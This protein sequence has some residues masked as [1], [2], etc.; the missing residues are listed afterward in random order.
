M[1]ES[2]WGYNQELDAYREE[3]V[4]DH[5]LCGRV[6][7]EHKERYVVITTKQ[8]YQCE[9]LGNLRHTAT[10]RPD[11][12]AVGDW[13]YFQ[14][15]DEDRGIIHGLFPRKTLL[16][17]QAVGK[18][19]E[20]QLI[21]TNID[22]AFIL[23]ALDRDFS[24]NRIQRYLALLAG[25]EIEAKVLLT[26]GDLMSQ[27]QVDHAI[28][29]A[30]RR[31]PDIEVISVS[32]KD[33]TG[34][35][36]IHEI[37]QA[38]K[39]YCLLGSSGVGKSTLLNNLL[40]HEEMKTGNTS[41]SSNRGKHVTTHRHLVMLDSGAMI[42]DNPGMREVGMVE[43]DGELESVFG[44]IGE[45]SISCRFKDCTHISEKGCAVLDALEAGK[46]SAENYENF[47]RL[48]REQ[49]HFEASAYERKQK[50]KA[51]G[52]MIKKHKKKR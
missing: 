37:L 31:L 4:P 5:L 17:R 39:T 13:V 1:D 48:Q 52:K 28:D 43:T 50:D 21:A 16:E 8:E 26:K 47:M 30:S 34:Y 11:F 24:I 18:E 36:R 51:L 9:I 2:I 22:C 10:S 20:R 46:L 7:L 19:G 33:R 12:P 3:H 29:D 35:S 45:L 14:E 27:V 38:G 41:D 40:D 44:S 49:H 42:I 25:S 15:F 23:V 6:I 32:N